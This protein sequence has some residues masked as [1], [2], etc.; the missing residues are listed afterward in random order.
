MLRLWLGESTQSPAFVPDRQ[1]TRYLIVRQEDAWFIKF[2]GEDYGPYI[3]EREAM[4]FAVDAAQKLGSQGEETEVLLVD[5]HGELTPVWS[6]GLDP[7]AAIGARQ[8]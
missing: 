1:P 6:Y 4:L 2:E 3:S 7:A 5:E 8:P